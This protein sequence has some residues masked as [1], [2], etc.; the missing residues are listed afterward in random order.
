MQQLV[1]VEI[2]CST[3]ATI[4]RRLSAALEQPMLQ[5]MAFARRQPVAFAR[6]QPVAY[7]VDE[8][9]RA[10]VETGA[11]TGNAD[12]GNPKGKRSWQWVM[13]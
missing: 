9:L 10:A 12:G 1:G 13:W 5:A 4:R 7:V 11:P 6:R 2:S 8:V 3:I